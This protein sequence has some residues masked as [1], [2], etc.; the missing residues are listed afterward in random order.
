MK[1][2]LIPLLSVMVVLLFTA[3]TFALHA[4]PQ[5]YEYEPQVVKAAKSMIKLS[6]S[7]RIRGEYSDNLNDYT[8][9]V[10]SD[11]SVSYYD[12]RIRLRLDATISPNTMG[13]IELENGRGDLCEDLGLTDCN[14]PYDS[15]LSDGYTWGSYLSGATNY[16]RGNSKIGDLRIRQAYIAHQ[17][18]SLLGRLAGFK[19][20]HMPLKVGNG[21]FLNH[22]KFGDDVITFWVSGSELSFTAAKLSEG[23]G[24]FSDDADAYI[25]TAETEMNGI[26]LGADVTYI[27]DNAFDKVP[28]IATGK[29]RGLDLWNIGLR[30]STEVQ[31]I[32][33]RADVEIQTGEAKEGYTDRNG[34]YKDREY[35]GYAFL[36]GAD[37]KLGDI[38]ITAE[39]AYGSG[40]E[41]DYSKAAHINED[42]AVCDSGDEYEGFVTS[43]SSG[44]KYTY[45]YDQKV[46]TAA[47]AKN[48]GLENTWYLKVGAS[49]RV[50]P[51]LKVSG[52]LYYLR[53]AEDTNIGGARKNTASAAVNGNL[54]TSK[55][56]GVEVDCKVE[57]QIDKNLV[58]YIEA[59]YLFA[60][61]AYKVYDASAQKNKDPD[62]PFSV[63]HGIILKF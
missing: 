56:L 24:A 60:G 3:S 29:N 2:T 10:D 32:N 36:I 1:K 33:V 30:A 34:N 23:S 43:L 50:N 6:G 63:R 61:D 42:I 26:K 17:G 45:L 4:A 38:T 41:C 21:L 58:Y 11:N 31:G 18:K 39:G 28:D 27:N 16:Q 7:I 22:A 13:V 48:T 47:R 55:D 14:L 54:E 8:D 9:D 53:A 40:D 37:V 52:A 46:A 35:K 20:G 19:A 57:Y 49:T 5:G 15:D 44:Q 12:Q 25:L 59:G 51:D 62:D